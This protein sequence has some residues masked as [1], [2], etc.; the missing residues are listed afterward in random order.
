MGTE[1]AEHE[2]YFVGQLDGELAPR[3]L[4][5]RRHGVIDYAVC[6]LHLLEV[7]Q[8]GCGATAHIGERRWAIRKVVKC[9]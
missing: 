8:C 5:E 6:E 2:R 4:D 1:R 7:L 9:S 3:E